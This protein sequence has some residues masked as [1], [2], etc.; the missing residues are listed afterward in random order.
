MVV[1]VRDL[2]ELG[3]ALKTEK[4][5]LVCKLVAI[6]SIFGSL[7]GEGANTISL[8]TTTFF[9]VVEEARK[10][11]PVGWTEPAFVYRETQRVFEV[12]TCCRVQIH[13]D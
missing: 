4:G 2:R 5:I 8:D 1:Q 9:E 7:K 3:T 10:S 6:E 13:R 11:N 12:L